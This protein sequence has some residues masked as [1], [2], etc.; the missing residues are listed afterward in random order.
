MTELEQATRRSIEA[1]D[2]GD[3]AALKEALTARD[4]AIGELSGLAPSA[5][6][7]ARLD[8]AIQAGDAVHQALQTLKLR[9]SFESGRLA[10]LQ[11]GLV[12]GLGSSPDPYIELF[13]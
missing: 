1:T 2:A 4:V 11:A 8:A 9:I 12:S 5:D 13:F 3:L 7:A 10:Q 6:L